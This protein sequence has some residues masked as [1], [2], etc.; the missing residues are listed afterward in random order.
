[1]GAFKKSANLMKEKW[2]ESIG[3]GFSFFLIE[4]V[5]ILAIGSVSFLL[6]SINVMVGIA[7]AVIG[8]LLLL[9]VISAVKT[10]FISTIYHNI[11]GDPVELYN[12][13]F[14]DNLFEKKKK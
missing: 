13:Q 11:Q 4:L 7:V 12:Q 6:A 9:T 5:A 8:L 3:A 14:I 1:V 2:G 10:I